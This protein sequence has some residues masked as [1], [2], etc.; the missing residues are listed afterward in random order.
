M[1][2]YEIC[3]FGG[4]LLN[5]VCVSNCD[6]CAKIKEL[7]QKIKEKQEEDDRRDNCYGI[8]ELK[9]GSLS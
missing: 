7:S 3:V 8:E 4:E 5:V 1:L 2:R 6:K 9:L